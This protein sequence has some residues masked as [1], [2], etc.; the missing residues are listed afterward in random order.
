MMECLCSAIGGGWD[1]VLVG[2]VVVVGGG[3]VWGCGHS[4]GE[5]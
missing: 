5:V 3:V 4:T 2:I 1:G